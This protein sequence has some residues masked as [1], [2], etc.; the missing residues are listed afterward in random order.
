MRHTVRSVLKDYEERWERAVILDAAWGERP[1]L[2]ANLQ[3]DWNVERLSGPLPMPFVWKRIRNGRG[4]T[5]VL[6]APRA[7]G[8]PLVPRFPFRLEQREGHVV[9]IYTGLL[10]F[11]VDELRLEAD[12]S[13]LG[14]ANAAGI[15]YAWFA[16]TPIWTPERPGKLH[17]LSSRGYE[18]F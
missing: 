12:G 16:M 3:G 8:V 9:L 2:V 11:L 17:N 15:R 6:P 18:T 1:S 7:R 13:W 10:S 14:R 5:Y 4:E